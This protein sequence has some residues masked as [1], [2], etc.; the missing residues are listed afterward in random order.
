M[1]T[2]Q[3]V[4]R[5][6]AE[7]ALSLKEISLDIHVEKNIGN[8]V[9]VR[10]EKEN[11]IVNYP[12]FCKHIKV[13]TPSGDCFEFPCYCWLE[14]ENEVM[15][16]EGT[17]RLPQDDTESFQEHRKDQLE[18]R[19]KIFRWTE[20]SPG[21]PRSIDAKVDDLPKEVQFYGEKKLRVETGFNESVS[22]GTVSWSKYLL[23][24]YRISLCFAEGIQHS[25]IS[26]K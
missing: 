15:I 9:Q 4:T 21:F 13:Q 17:A 12:W 25:A 14:D 19:Q 8:I 20:W 5:E 18:C 16:Q 6:A 3:E 7:G 2:K 24:C 11:I 1:A 22:L 26:C 10:L 23:I